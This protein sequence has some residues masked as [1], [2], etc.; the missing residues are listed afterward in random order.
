MHNGTEVDTQGDAFF[1]SFARARDAAAAAV[2]AQRALAAHDWPGESE[3]RVRMG[4]HTGEPQVGEDGYLGL[5]VVRASR[6][7][8]GRPRRPGA[9]SNTTRALLGSRLARGGPR[10]TNSAS[11]R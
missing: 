4:L 3:V 10:F 9:P 6:I 5:D 11:S 2:E 8:L 7:L 1:Y